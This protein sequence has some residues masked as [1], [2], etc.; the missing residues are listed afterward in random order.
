MAGKSFLL[1]DGGLYRISVD[2][3]K[4]M[5]FLVEG[6]QFSFFPSISKEGDRLV[7]SEQIY[8]ADIWRIDL[9]LARR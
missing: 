2:G 5:F 3:G 6:G 9:P 8:E 1:S 7:Y 4:A